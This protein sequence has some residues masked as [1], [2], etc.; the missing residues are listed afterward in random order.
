MNDRWASNKPV[1]LIGA[2][3][4]WQLSARIAMAL[5]QHGCTVVAICPQGHP[6]RLV[7]GIRDLYLYGSINS[8]ETLRAAILKSRPDVIVPCD[9][10]VVLQLHALHQRYP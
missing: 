4:W 6:L 3:T 1:L 9:D 10:G 7:S 8:L 2:T 5:V